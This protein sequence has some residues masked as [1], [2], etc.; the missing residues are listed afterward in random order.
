MEPHPLIIGSDRVVRGEKLLD[1]TSPYDGSTV[2]RVVMGDEKLLD[3]AVNAAQQA[4]E[5]TTR[6]MPPFER[7]RIL[8]GA[9]ERLRARRD[10]FAQTIVAEAGKP[11]VMAEAEV[12]RCVITLTA[13]AEEAR[14]F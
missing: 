13:A 7:S 3:A 10:E 1:V 6:R 5:S 9:A 8:A 14:K 2:G 4:F 12:D 11:I